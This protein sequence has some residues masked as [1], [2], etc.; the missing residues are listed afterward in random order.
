[1]LELVGENGALTLLLDHAK[2]PYKKG[3]GLILASP[4]E[5]HLMTIKCFESLAFM[6]DTKDPPAEGIKLPYLSA[7][8]QV[9]LKQLYAERHPEQEELLYCKV[10]HVFI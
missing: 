5:V 2:E 9:F 7:F 3:N 10:C 1:M 4:W 6:S 8:A